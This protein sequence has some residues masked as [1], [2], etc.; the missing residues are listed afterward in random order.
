MVAQL[1]VAVLVLAFD[2]CF[3]DRAVQTL[4]LAAFEGF[5]RLGQIMIP[6]APRMVWLDQPMFDAVGRADHVETH[7]L[8]IDCI[9]IARLL[10]EL[11]AIVCQNRVDTVKHNFQK[12]L[13]ELPRRLAIG[14]LHQ[15][16][17]GELAGSVNGY[18]EKKLTFFGSDFGDVDMN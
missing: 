2:S 10:G 7:R 11:D 3:P 5:D 9:A 15:L 13:K 1:I 8:R 4:N 12:I 6:E 14:F 16:C 17:D 18:K